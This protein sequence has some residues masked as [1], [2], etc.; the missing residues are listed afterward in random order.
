LSERQKAQREYNVGDPTASFF[1]A[2]ISQP[3]ID[4]IGASGQFTASTNT[5][6]V[7][8]LSFTVNVASKVYDVPTQILQENVVLNGALVVS[9]P[10]IVLP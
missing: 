5:A 1:V 10:S 6:Y 4:T 9:Q 3:I 8:F 2:D 7:G